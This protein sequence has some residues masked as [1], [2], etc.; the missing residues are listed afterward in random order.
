MVDRLDPKLDVDE[1]W[2]DNDNLE[3]PELINFLY[4]C[5]DLDCYAENLVDVLYRNQ[6]VAYTLF[7][8]SHKMPEGLDFIRYE[9]DDFHYG[10][11][12]DLNAHQVYINVLEI[13]GQTSTMRSVQ[14]FQANIFAG[15]GPLD[16][17]NAQVKM[18][19]KYLGVFRKTLMTMPPLRVVKGFKGGIEGYQTVDIIPGAYR[20]DPQK[21]DLAPLKEKLGAVPELIY[22]FTAITVRNN[23]ISYLI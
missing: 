18:A 2:E 12:I 14:T 6:D 9:R 3:T 11:L 17:P 19:S 16:D 5:P 13:D 20:E 10:T 7:K 23:L 4:D 8:Q 1:Y 22:T 15:T 21:A